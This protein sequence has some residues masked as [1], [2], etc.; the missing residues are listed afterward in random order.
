M[1]GDPRRLQVEEAADEL[2]VV[3][4]PVVDF[5]QEGD[6][7]IQR[8]LQSPLRLPHRG[9]VHDGAD[10]LDVADT[11]PQATGVPPLKPR[12]ANPATSRITATRPSPRMVAP[13]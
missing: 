5:L 1:I 13:A 12:A 6:L 7:L 2:Q 3:L 10:V 4:D 11:D 8:V 9:D